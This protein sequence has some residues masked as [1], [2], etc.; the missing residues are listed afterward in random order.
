[1]DGPSSSCAEFRIFAFWALLMALASRVHQN[2]GPHLERS[3]ETGA[4]Q[5]D[6][7]QA[8]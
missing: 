4:P 6:S 8:P 7:A 3:L 2:A 1:M 5:S